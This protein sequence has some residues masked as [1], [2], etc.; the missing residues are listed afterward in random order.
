M[1]ERELLQQLLA[2]MRTHLTSLDDLCDA[3][4]HS[5]AH[6]EQAFSGAAADAKAHGEMLSEV[7]QQRYSG[8]LREAQENLTI[9]LSGRE[10][11]HAKLRQM[12]D[13]IAKL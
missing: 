8:L 5:L 13:R 9:A 6:A 7:E 10:A 4:R 11:F 3:A 12:E 2:G 1:A